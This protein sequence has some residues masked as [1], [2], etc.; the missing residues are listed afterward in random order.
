MLNALV[1]FSFHLCNK[2]GGGNTDYFHFTEKETE[3]QRCC[4]LAH[5]YPASRRQSW[6]PAAAPTVHFFRS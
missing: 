6:D 3:A 5:S 2:Q 4:N 1:I